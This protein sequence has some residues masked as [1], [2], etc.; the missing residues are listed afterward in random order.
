MP[1]PAIQSW[2]F[3]DATE[4]LPELKKRETT[5]DKECYFELKTVQKIINGYQ[6][7]MKI[8]PNAFITAL[9]FAIPN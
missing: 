3:S 5:Q 9:I 2:I 4:D 6:V 8:Y 1:L 7:Y